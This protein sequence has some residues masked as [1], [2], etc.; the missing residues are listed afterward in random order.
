MLLLLRRK[1]RRGSVAAGSGV[2]L[3][4]RAMEE[5]IPF[6]PGINLELDGESCFCVSYLRGAQSA[7]W[8]DWPQLSSGEG[9]RVLPGPAADAPV[10]LWVFISAYAKEPSNYFHLHAHSLSKYLPAPET[11]TK[12]LLRNGEVLEWTP[13]GK[14]PA[15]KFLN[16]LKKAT[17]AQPLA[18]Y[19]TEVSASKAEGLSHLDASHV[20]HRSETTTAALAW[21]IAGQERQ[22]DGQAHIGFHRALRF[23][24]D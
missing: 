9:F 3:P 2:S 14:N 4:R 19:P 8:T 10:A 22:F 21:Q 20:C 16:N 12:Y 18:V 6:S 7:A 1:K 5:V 11:G 23:M 15:Q 17:P 24:A 13:E